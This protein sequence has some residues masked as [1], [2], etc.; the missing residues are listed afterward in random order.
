MTIN[1]VATIIFSAMVGATALAIASSR[2]RFLTGLFILILIHALGELLIASGAYQY[3]P[4]LAGI[5]LPIRMLLGPAL[6]FYAHSMMASEQLKVSRA[7]GLALLG[8]VVILLIM[9]PFVG[10]SAEQKLSLANPATRDPVL[11]QLAITTCALAAGIFVAYTAAYLLAAL[12]LQ[13]RHRARMMEQYA[14][15][16]TRSLDWL[17][18][19]LLVWGLVW[20]LFAVDRAL[21]IANIRPGPFGIILALAEAFAVIAFAHLALNQ[22]PLPDPDTNNE[23]ENTRTREPT[24]SQ[25]RMARIAEKLK[26]CMLEDRLFTENELSLRHLADATN[27]SENHLS[28]TFSQYLKTNFFQFV[29]EYRIN[30]AK[31]LLQRADSSITT[32]AFDIGY[33]SRSTFNTAFK[34]STGLTPSAFRNQMNSVQSNKLSS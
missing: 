24:L 29:N 10:L 14:N 4:H 7:Y 33:N 26:T 30:E 28:E 6:Y 31:H 15:I 21:W 19:M 25:E 1:I 16:E 18:I 9:L 27:T 13:N 3:A 22:P 23:T 11:W 17:R 2:N 5:Q 20:L 12:R 8:P 34:K 32:I